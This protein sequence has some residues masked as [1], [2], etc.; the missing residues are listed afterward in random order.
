MLA[1]QLLSLTAS[2]LITGATLYSLAAFSNARLHP[3][4]PRSTGNLTVTHL[5]DPV[6]HAT[7]ASVAPV[8]PGKKPGAGIPDNGGD[9]GMEPGSEHTGPAL[10][11]PYYSFTRTS[12][13]I[14][15]KD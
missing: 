13:H 3:T 15:E 12:P 10:R 8:R 9:T 14:L 11:M 6:D 7:V 4:S 5:P 2:L 1:R